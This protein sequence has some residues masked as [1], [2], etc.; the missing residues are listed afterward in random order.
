MKQCMAERTPRKYSVL[1]SICFVFCLVAIIVLLTFLLFSLFIPPLLVVIFMFYMREDY[2]MELYV[3][4]RKR[5]L[6]Q[7]NPVIYLPWQRRVYGK[8]R[9]NG[10]QCCDHSQDHDIS[11]DHFMEHLLIIDDMIC[12]SL[13]VIRDKKK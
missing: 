13:H 1:V 7:R 4:L 2:F 6:W 5:G 3:N 12:F 11:T 10:T 8:K 9:G